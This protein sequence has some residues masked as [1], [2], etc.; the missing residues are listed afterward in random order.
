S[1]MVESTVYLTQD[2]Q[3]RWLDESYVNSIAWSDDGSVAD[4]IDQLEGAFPDV[5]AHA[6]EDFVAEQQAQITNG[7]DIIAMVLL[8]FAAIALLTSMMVIANTFSIL[9]AQRTRD[10]A[11]LRC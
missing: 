5:S 4:Q 1:M 7:V 2:A 10:F 8:V 6:P 9:F 11:L 3:Q